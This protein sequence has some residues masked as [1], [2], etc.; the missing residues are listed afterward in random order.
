MSIAKLNPPCKI[1]SILEG[2]YNP[3]GLA[4]AVE[5][6]VRTLLDN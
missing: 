1:I 3:E 2:G 6:H 5:A 4:M